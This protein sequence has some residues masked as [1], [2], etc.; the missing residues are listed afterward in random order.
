MHSVALTGDVMLGRGI[1]QILPHP[2]D[3]AIHE[4][5]ARS[6]LTYLALAERRNGPIR[7]PAGFAYVWG[8]ALP[9]LRSAAIRIVNLETSVTTSDSPEAKGIHYRMHPDNIGCLRAAGIECC[10][11]ANNHVLDWG[12]GGLLQ[13]LGTLAQAGIATAGAGRNAA[14]AEQ[15][16][17]MPLSAG[18]RLLVLAAGTTSSGIPAGWA[19]TATQPG[20]HL[21]Q[22]PLSAAVPRLAT[23]LRAAKRSGDIAVASI[24]W[25]PNW[26]YDIPRELRDA[27]HALIDEAGFDVV[28]G[29]SSH[30]PLGIEV[31]RNRLI[32]YG[33]GDFIN[34]YEGIEGYEEFR[35]DL[36]LLY[37]P[38]LSAATGE[39]LGLTLVPFRI[40]RFRLNRA[41][42][43]DAGWLRD[44]L[45]R[46][47]LRF[48]TR[49]GMAADGTLD[50]AWRGAA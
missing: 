43:A 47:S 16:A 30:H 19:A 33:A 15:P 38:R 40:G 26:G 41:S 34:D 13:T 9:A 10:V 11:L 2:G 42:A 50:A 23:L 20:V 45:D 44:T 3:P 28:H 8:D 6:A 31:H 14:Q 25:G 21:L 32:L 24:H 48:G 17:V 5:H 46:E 29:H 39:L 49:I 1:D 18:G 37:L 36:T 35:G 4:C 22:E 7:R 27:A 12:R